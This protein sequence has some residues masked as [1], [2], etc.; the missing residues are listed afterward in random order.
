MSTFPFRHTSTPSP[1]AR[2]QDGLLL[3]ASRTHSAVGGGGGHSLRADAANP[4][5]PATGIRLRP[6]HRLHVAGRRTPHRPLDLLPVS[7]TKFKGPLKDLFQQVGRVAMRMGFIR[8]LEKA[9]MLPTTRPSWRQTGRGISSS[10]A[11]SSP[12][13]TNRT[14][15]CRAW[16]ASPR[17]SAKNRKPR[18]RTARLPRASI[19]RTWRPA[20]ST[21]TRPSNRPNRSKEI[22]P[23]GKIRGS[24]WR[25]NNGRTCLATIR[26]NWPSRLL[27][28]MP[29][30]TSISAR[31]ARSALPGDEEAR[32][33]AGAGGSAD[34]RLQ[35]LCGL[36][37]V[38]GVP[39]SEG[40][41]RADDQLRRPRTGAAADA[42]Q[43]AHG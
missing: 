21:S 16:T 19:S 35:R 10:T 27:C 42:R 40:Q 4:L 1:S 26:G 43:T 24:R 29:P 32:R 11:R 36:S 8:L 22:Q 25:K 13:P 3:H 12:G 5:Q 33:L 6:Q 2:L 18:R 28:T 17:I 15:C 37:A 20:A 30:A 7:R 14:N 38:R 34:L 31:W 23:S 39:R 9:A 41:A